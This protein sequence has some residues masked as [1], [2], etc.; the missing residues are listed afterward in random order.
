[1]ADEEQA[2]AQ[3]PKR[4]REDVEAHRA[5]KRARRDRADETFA[6]QLQAFSAACRALDKVEKPTCTDVVTV[7]NKFPD[8]NA[9]DRAMRGGMG[10]KY[11]GFRSKFNLVVYL[12]RMHPDNL[13]HFVKYV[14]LEDGTDHFKYR[15]ILRRTA[16]GIADV[17]DGFQPASVAAMLPYF[18][19]DQLEALMP[20][21]S[22]C[23][24]F[25]EVTDAIATALSGNDVVIRTLY[26]ELRRHHKPGRVPEPQEYYTDC[27]VS[28]AEDAEDA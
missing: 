11:T 18:D 7:L 9:Y 19:P 14:L 8:Y 22:Y 25:A 2:N 23:P 16:S 20:Y 1:M 10:G 13:H 27:S 12:P 26:A 15:G 17:D 24:Y 5:A 4:S 6:Q 3:R 28:D 21:L